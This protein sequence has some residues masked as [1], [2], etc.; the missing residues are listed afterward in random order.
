LKKIAPSG[1]K[2]SSTLN[3]EDYLY[4]VLLPQNSIEKVT[5][6]SE[7]IDAVNGGSAA[8]I[9]DTLTLRIYHGH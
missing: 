5:A 9:V 6:F 8:L 2:K 3:L 4:N 7:L 1:I